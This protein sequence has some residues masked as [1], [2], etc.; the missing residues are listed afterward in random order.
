MLDLW[1]FRLGHYTQ[2]NRPWKILNQNLIYTLIDLAEKAR[3]GRQPTA[4]NRR[5][6]IRLE[7]GID[8]MLAVDDSP[9]FGPPDSSSG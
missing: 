1:L 5:I 2:L 7:P 6:F 8:E 4:A 3:I 9:R